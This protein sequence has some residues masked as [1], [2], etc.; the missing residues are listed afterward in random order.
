MATHGKISRGSRGEGAT[1]A[2]LAYRMTAYRTLRCAPS[3]IIGGHFA[4]LGGAA[5][6]AADRRSH[7][8]ENKD[9]HDPQ[10]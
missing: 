6:S 10:S 9:R 2:D 3:S 5:E 4:L 1:L 7:P 8:F